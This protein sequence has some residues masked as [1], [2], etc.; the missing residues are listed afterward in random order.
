MTKQLHNN[1]VKQEKQ[2]GTIEI[3]TEETHISRV[4]RKLTTK[5]ISNNSVFSEILQG[6][7]LQ[8]Y[9]F[10]LDNGAAS[11]RE[12]HK[13]LDFS[14]PGLAYY[15]IKKLVSAGMVIKDDDTDKYLINERVKSGLLNFYVE[16]GEFFIPR[17]S[18]YLCVFLLGFLLF[19]LF[20][21]ILGDS[22]ITNP[23]TILLFFFLLF[24]SVIFIYES[25]K[26][27]KLKPN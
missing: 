9:W 8:V 24:G 15:Q 25:M 23:G 14:S 22:F 2:K 4:K 6:K 7:T 20:A 11:I 26:I 12:V 27:N 18:L 10:L 19:F 16:I 17:Y 21:L 5:G 13:A 3:E 1:Q